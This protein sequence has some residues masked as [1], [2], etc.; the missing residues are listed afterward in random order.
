[1]VLSTTQLFSQAD[2]C[3]TFF[4]IKPSISGNLV[5]ITLTN[6]NLSI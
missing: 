3:V 6:E 1:M 2:S 5:I 4:K